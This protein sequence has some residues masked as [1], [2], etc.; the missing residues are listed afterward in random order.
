MELQDALT[1]A[2]DRSSGVLA[3][4]RKS[5]RPQLSNVTYLAGDDGTLR[6]SALSS[7]AKVH[8]IRRD[9][10]VSLH[11]TDEAFSTWVVF[12]CDAALSA[13]AR[14]DAAV[15][16]EL[17]EF[18]SLLGRENVA[19]DEF[20]ATLIADDRLILRLRPTDAYGNS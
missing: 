7:R 10:R 18:F 20:R 15:V 11:V 13:S 6:V 14:D 5:G 1:W 9:G 2:R 3:T 17:V 19:T 16:D 4:Q 12:E 8:N